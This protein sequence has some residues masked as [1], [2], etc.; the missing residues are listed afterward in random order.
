[1]RVELI[2]HT[3]QSYL[4]Y[5]FQKDIA[6]DEYEVKRIFDSGVAEFL[7]PNDIY[8]LD[9]PQIRQALLEQFRKRIEESG[10]QHE[11]SA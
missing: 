10:R 7:F 4:N 8:N 3:N 6:H 9:M 1:M 11:N 5:L 2:I